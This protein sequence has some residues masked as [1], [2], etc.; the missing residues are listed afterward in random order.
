MTN[1]DALMASHEEAIPAKLAGKLG[2]CADCC[3]QVLEVVEK[4]KNEK[5]HLHERLAMA[6]IPIPVNI[7]MFVKNAAMPAAAV[8]DELEY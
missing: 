6:A 4:L 1:S 2:T 3:C 7:V 5:S 8:K